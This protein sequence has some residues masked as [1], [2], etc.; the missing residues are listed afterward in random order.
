MNIDTDTQY[1]FTRSVAG[2]MFTQLRRRAQGRRQVG[3]KKAYD[4]RAWGKVAESAMAARVVEA[5]QQLGSAGAVD[6]RRRSRMSEQRRRRDP[7]RAGR[8]AGAAG[9]PRAARTRARRAPAP[10]VRRVRARGLDVAAAARVRHTSDPAPQMATPPGRGVA[11][12]PRLRRRPRPERAADRAV[13][14]LL[15]VIG[16]LGMWGAISTLQSLPDQLPIAIRQASGC[17]APMSRASSTCPD[18][19]CP[20]S[21]S[22]ARSPR[23]SSGCSARRLDRAP[24]ARA[25][26]SFWL[27]LAGGFVV[28]IVL[29]VFTAIALS[30]DPALIEQLTTTAG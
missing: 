12:R 19:R 28:S 24:C 22:R 15:L 10:A 3:N 26:P 6:Q 13:T 20:A 4:P 9:A 16:V 17:S 5:T 14:I 1:A 30:G 21:C 18:P 2:Y 25:R 8:P 29:V 7:R 11:P 23:S 27:P